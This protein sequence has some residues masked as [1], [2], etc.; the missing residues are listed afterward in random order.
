VQPEVLCVGLNKSFDFRIYT[1]DEQ[2][3]FSHV[4]P[5]D[6]RFSPILSREQAWYIVG[7]I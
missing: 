3:H 6:L 5:D 7:M 1:K 2:Q 4:T